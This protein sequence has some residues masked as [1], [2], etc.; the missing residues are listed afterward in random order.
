MRRKKK[1]KKYASPPIF[2]FTPETISLTLEAIRRFEQPLEQVTQQ[3]DK[4]MFAIEETRR[5]KAMLEAM[6]I[7]AEAGHMCVA[8]FDYNDKVLLVTAIQMYTF[9][10]NMQ[11]ASPRQAWELEQCR[12]IAAY[13]APNRPNEQAGGENVL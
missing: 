6:R 8:A 1:R 3:D 13:F 2:L 10:L 11:P 4:I 12:R 9:D 7:E 5:V